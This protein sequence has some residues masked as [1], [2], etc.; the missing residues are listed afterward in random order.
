[1]RNERGC[2]APPR[3]IR[4]HTTRR[5]RAQRLGLITTASQTS[6]HNTRRKAMRSDWG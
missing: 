3:N 2:T 6:Y 1:M 5:H 4:T